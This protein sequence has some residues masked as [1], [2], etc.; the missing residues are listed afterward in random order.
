LSNAGTVIV[1]GGAKGIGK[2]ISEMFAQNNYNVL[3]N[4]WKSEEDADNLCKKLIK[5]GY[6]SVSTYKADVSDRKQIREMIKFCLDKYMTI[7]I[8][9]NNAGVSHS[10]LFC[11]I[12]EEEWDEVIDINLKGVF[13]CCQAVMP[14]YLRQ[15]RGSIVNISSIW[16]MVGASCEVHYSAA[17]A[18]VIGLTK[19]LAKEFGISGIRVNCVAPGAINT[20]MLSNL[21]EDEMN[22]IKKETPLQRIGTTTDIANAVFFLATDKSDFITGQVLSP[23]GGFVI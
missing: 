10:N 21:N 4:Y 22:V 20:E 16:G 5:E 2:S 13:N 14:E 18:G 3:I 23:N 19:A 15:K 1:T 11:D 7:D 8:L 12:E 6:S 17:K 9:I